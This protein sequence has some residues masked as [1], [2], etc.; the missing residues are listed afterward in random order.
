MI[1]VTRSTS[2]S[3]S[4][5]AAAVLFGTTGTAQALGAA[6]VDPTTLGAARIVLGGVVL[7]AIAALTTR[8][9]TGRGTAAPTQSRRRV[10]VIVLIGALGVAAYQP[11]FFTG[12]RENGVAIGTILALGSAPIFTGALEW[13]VFRRAP[14]PRWAVSTGVALVGVVL[15]ALSGGGSG[16]ITAIGTAG[17]LGAG[18]SYSVYAVCGKLLLEAGWTPAQA[19]AAEFGF[20]AIVMLPVLVLSRPEQLGSI[21]ALATVGWLGVATVAIAYTLF[22]R[23]LKQLPAARVSTLTLVEPATATVLGV[24]VLHETLG[25]AALSGIVLVVAAVAILALGGRAPRDAATLTP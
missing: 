16:S 10:T 8:A 5:I 14:G 23:G 18:L 17:S 25:L 24:L 6:D 7:A 20:A 2:A 22:A 12:T 11:A 4:V 21:P 15:I 1:G 3:L 13:V 9:G 19:M